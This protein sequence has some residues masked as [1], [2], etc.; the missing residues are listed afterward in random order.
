[1]LNWATEIFASEVTV[2][3]VD[4]AALWGPVLVALVV[5]IFGVVQTVVARKT[6]HAA[7][8]TATVA[9]GVAESTA[10]AAQVSGETSHSHLELLLQKQDLV[11]RKQTDI[12][13]KIEANRRTAR[14]DVDA[15]ATKID[16]LSGDM[17]TLLGLMVNLEA[18]VAVKAEAML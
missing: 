3:G 17:E 8:N 15:V 6:V 14:R 1:M 2:G 5:G 18:K 4:V 9:A 7:A 10:I 13:N 11:L 16:T 12:Q